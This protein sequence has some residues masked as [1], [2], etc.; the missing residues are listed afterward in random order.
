MRRH[1]APGCPAPVTFNVRPHMHWVQ[2]LVAPNQVFFNLRARF[3]AAVVRQLPQ[4]F[5]LVPIT[6]E[7]ARELQPLAEADP[8]PPLVEEIEPGVT[9]LGCALSDRG[10]VVYVATFI[11]GGTG[12]QDALVWRNGELALKLVETEDTMSKWPDSSIS[13]ALRAAGVVAREGEDEFDALGLGTHRSNEA[14]AAGEGPVLP[15]SD[16]PERS[17]TPKQSIPRSLWWRLWR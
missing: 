11:H 17:A 4:G 7:L 13:R 10:V 2:A 1:A 9:A 5:S 14:W 8:A 3:P 12:G 16:L 15:S 6:D